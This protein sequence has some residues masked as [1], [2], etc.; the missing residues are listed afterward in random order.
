MLYASTSSLTGWRIWRKKMQIEDLVWLLPSECQSGMIVGVFI[1]WSPYPKYGNNWDGIP[2][3]PIC[4]M[5]GEFVPTQRVDMGVPD[6]IMA[7]CCMISKGVMGLFQ[8]D[9]EFATVVIFDR[10]YRIPWE[11][12]FIICEYPGEE[13]S[14]EEKAG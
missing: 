9:S 7:N 4:F 12:P 3:E 5:A 13:G 10:N 6:K 2:P 11:M 1:M 8:E 14:E